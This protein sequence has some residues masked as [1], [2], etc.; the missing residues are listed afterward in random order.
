[1]ISSVL[2]SVKSFVVLASGFQEASLYIKNLG[3]DFSLA[4][5]LGIIQIV[6]VL[7]KQITSCQPWDALHRT[8]SETAYDPVR[9]EYPECHG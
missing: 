2:E 7:D 1:M 4:N 6:F 3:K 5:G 8:W 9:P